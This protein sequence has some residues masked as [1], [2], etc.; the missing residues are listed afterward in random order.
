MIF[1]L[2]VYELFYDEFININ[3]TCNVLCLTTG[4][5]VNTKGQGRAYAVQCRKDAYQSVAKLI[6]NSRLP[7]EGDSRNRTIVINIREVADSDPTGGRTSTCN[8]IQVDVVGYSK[9]CSRE[10]F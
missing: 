9:A 8:N 6:D 4:A 10:I 3:F 5:P 7:G 2:D 1:V